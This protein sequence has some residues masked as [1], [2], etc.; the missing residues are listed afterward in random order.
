MT[1]QLKTYEITSAE[2]AFD[3]ALNL[4]AFDEIFLRPDGIDADQLRNDIW[5]IGWK[6]EDARELILLKKDGG[7]SA[8]ALPNSEAE[9]RWQPIDPEM[10]LSKASLQEQTI[11]RS[12]DFWGEYN[13]GHGGIFVGTQANVNC[14]MY[15]LRLIQK[16][17][18]AGFKADAYGFMGEDNPTAVIFSDDCDEE[19]SS[20]LSYPPMGPVHQGHDF[21][22]LRDPETDIGRWIVDPWV[23]DMECCDTQGV[24]D[25]LDP[26][27]AEKIRVI[28]GD[29]D[30]WE[31]WNLHTDGTSLKVAMGSSGLVPLRGLKEAGQEATTDAYG[32]T[33]ELGPE[34]EPVGRT[35]A[36]TM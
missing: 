9:A 2:E 19:N 27:D 12:Y 35:S 30:T 26:R 25:L 36:M 20:C 29:P 22:V 33:A 8:I 32:V 1:A 28:Y 17:A 16:F 6:Y 10:E 13:G 14:T 21:C 11:N 15:A 7:L 5:N 34:G 4:N 23:S 18:Q 31:Q 3:I 24:Y